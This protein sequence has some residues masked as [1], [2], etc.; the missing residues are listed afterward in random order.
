M[1]SRCRVASRSSIRCLRNV[2]FCSR[3]HS[4]CSLHSRSWSCVLS[5]T[6]AS[7]SSTWRTTFAVLALLI[8]GKNGRRSVSSTASASPSPCTARAFA[9][10]PI[11]ASRFFAA[12]SFAVPLRPATAGA[13]AC[14]LRAGRSSAA[15]AAASTS[16]EAARGGMARSLQRAGGRGTERVRSSTP[17]LPPPRP[18][19]GKG[20]GTR[21]RRAHAA[22]AVWRTGGWRWWW[23]GGTAVHTHTTHTRTHARRR[24]A[25]ERTVRTAPDAGRARSGNATRRNESTINSFGAHHYPRESHIHPIDPIYVTSNR[26]YWAWQVRAGTRPVHMCVLRVRGQRRVY[27]TGTCARACACVRSCVCVRACACARA[28]ACVRTCVRVRA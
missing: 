4:T 10:A 2:R 27:S 16:M 5:G 20:D 3:A 21:A 14:A 8:S 15:G 19:E 1:S 12:S 11:A 9:Y 18:G 28:R 22:R 23:W 13:R 24:A 26:A 25:A 7:A 6:R 17:S